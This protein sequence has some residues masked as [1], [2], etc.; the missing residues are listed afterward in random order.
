A[1]VKTILT[2]MKSFENSL[3]LNGVSSETLDEYEN[4]M[5][6]ELSSDKDV[7]NKSLEAIRRNRK[8]NFKSFGDFLIFSTIHS[9]KGL[10]RDNIILVI[11]DAGKKMA[12]KMD[13]VVYTGITRAKKNLYIINVGLEKYDEFF[14]NNIE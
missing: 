2:I 1:E 9:F 7:A 6:S 4:I 10:E 3:D 11:S 12:S 5:N 8:L 13:E 14:K